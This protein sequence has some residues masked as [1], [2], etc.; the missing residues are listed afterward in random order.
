MCNIMPTTMCRSEKFCDYFHYLWCCA[1]QN[2]IY[3]N[4]MLLFGVYFDGQRALFTASVQHSVKDEIID[5]LISKVFV[6][7]EP[8]S[9]YLI[10]CC[11]FQMVSPFH[12]YDVYLRQDCASLAANCML[13]FHSGFLCEFVGRNK[14]ILCVFLNVVLRFCVYRNVPFYI[15]H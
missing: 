5:C 11:I 9:T 14:Q 2:H 1:I 10:I 13:F 12:L 3:W 6:L 4:S 7:C 15:F 8:N